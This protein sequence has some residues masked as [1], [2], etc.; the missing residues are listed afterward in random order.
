LILDSALREGI[1]FDEIVII[2]N[3]IMGPLYH[4]GAIVEIQSNAIDYIET[5]RSRL[6]KTKITVIDFQDAEFASVFKHNDWIHRTNIYYLHSA[7]EPNLF[8]QYVN[9]EFDY[10]ENINDRIDLMGSVHPHVYWNDGWCF[11]YVDQQFP[12]N[13]WHTC[14]NFLTSSEDPSIAHAY[15]SA[16]CTEL[17]ARNLRPHRF[18]KDIFSDSNQNLRNIRQLLPEYQFNI[19]RPDH[20]WPKN[21]LDPWR[22]SDELFWRANPSYKSFLSCLLC[23]YSHNPSQGFYNY[24]N[25]TDWHKVCTE[26]DYGGICSREFRIN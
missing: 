18:Q 10:L 3:Q 16:V 19:H 20:E 25:L 11:V 13:L 7:I 5:I 9:P 4:M 26:L 21:Y 6:T 1:F 23:Y 12:Q 17:E 2:K 22:P 8:Y 15:V 14:E 24:C